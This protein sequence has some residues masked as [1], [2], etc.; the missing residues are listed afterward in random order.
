MPTYRQGY[1]V[2]ALATEVLVAI[3]G[4]QSTMALFALGAEGQDFQKAF[5]SVY[6]MSWTDASLILS[7]VLAAEYATYGPPPK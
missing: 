1:A 6:G 7:K 5:Q 4:P 2:G 3:A